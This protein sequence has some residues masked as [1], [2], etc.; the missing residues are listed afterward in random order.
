MKEGS[1]R[2]QKC[3]PVVGVAGNLLFLGIAGSG[4]Q[5]D[6]CGEVEGVH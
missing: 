2:D 6:V 5:L 4:M 3:L 1:D